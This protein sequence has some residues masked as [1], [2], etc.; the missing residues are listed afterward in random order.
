MSENPTTDQIAREVQ[1]ELL[2]RARKRDAARDMERAA[3]VVADLENAQARR[4]A[5][6]VASQIARDAAQ[7]AKK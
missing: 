5:D 7:G 4:N 2:E 1:D 3:E 6:A